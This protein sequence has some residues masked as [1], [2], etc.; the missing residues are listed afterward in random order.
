MNTKSNLLRR[1]TIP[2]SLGM[3]LLLAPILTAAQPADRGGPP[4]GP[5]MEWILER[6][7]LTAEQE[8]AV[9]EL[10]TKHHDAMLEGR[11]QMCA[12]RAALRDQIEAEEL[13]EVAIREAAAAVA[14]LEADRAV[15]RARVHQQL[16]SILTP[17]QADQLQEMQR[18]W[19][20]RFGDCTEGGFGPHG[21]HGRRG[22]HGYGPGS[23]RGD[24]F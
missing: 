8:K 18:E 21:P 6:L 12:A 9:Q 16:R 2:L 14:A 5:H 15:E 24:T 11:E 17:D 13:N 20:G 3:I 1:M 7:D 19:R 22:R 4:P 10:F 23:R